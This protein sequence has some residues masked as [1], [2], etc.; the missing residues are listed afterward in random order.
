[1]INAQGFASGLL[2][3]TSIPIK[4]P[5]AHL[6]EYTD[7]K[8]RTVVKAQLLVDSN[9]K[10]LHLSGGWPGS[11][12]DANIFRQSSLHN[13]IRETYGPTGYFILADK[14]YALERNVMTPFRENRRY[15][16]DAVS[17]I[18]HF[19]KQHNLTQFKC[20]P[21]SAQLQPTPQQS[22]LCD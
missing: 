16:L 22:A 3:T 18:T 10:I 13:L 6:R 12:H 17:F 14:A 5:L 4:Q 9:Y 2:D 8:S 15:P 21:D 7:R 1:M 11:M 19:N 20:I